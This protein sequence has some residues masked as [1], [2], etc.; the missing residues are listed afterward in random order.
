ME[1]DGLGQHGGDLR[2]QPESL[3]SPFR[4]ISGSPVPS[5]QSPD[6][7]PVAG[8]PGTLRGSILCHLLSLLRPSEQSEPDLALP[9]TSGATLT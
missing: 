2:A 6:P 7:F 5:A 4:T 9:L 3:L 8:G 1:T